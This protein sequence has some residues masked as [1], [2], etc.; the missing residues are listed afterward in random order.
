MLLDKVGP[1]LARVSTK[2]P[3]RVEIATRP[4]KRKFT[5][6]Q[7]L[8]MFLFW[9]RQNVID[10]VLA[11]MCECDSSQ[12]RKYAS[13]FFS[14][15]RRWQT[16]NLR[17]LLTF[18]LQ[19]IFF[20]KEYLGNK[21]KLSSRHF[22]NMFSYSTIDNFILRCISMSCIVHIYKVGSTLLSVIILV[23][24][25]FD[26][27]LSLN[28]TTNGTAGG[29]WFNVDMNNFAV[30]CVQSCRSPSLT[31]CDANQRSI[32][33]LGWYVHNPVLCYIYSLHLRYPHSK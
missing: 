15:E 20:G 24:L 17:P 1:L 3:R 12:V 6:V 19:N 30:F 21:C 5:V 7:Q 29:L 25:F 13:L 14:R 16:R 32:Q 10:E 33:V 11:W 4:R 23:F 28:S 27:C 26:P 31:S 22:Q 8:L 2:T 18:S 9:F